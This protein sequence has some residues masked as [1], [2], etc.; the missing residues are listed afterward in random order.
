[1]KTDA[2]RP[3]IY[4]RI[5]NQIISS[6][7]QG[8]KPWTQP[9]NAAHAAGPVS[10]PLRHSGETYS[11][12]NV[13][14]LWATAMERGYAGPIWMTFKQAL[15]LG[16]CV[17]KGEKSSPVVYAGS[18][19]RTEQ[20]DKTGEDVERT[21]PFL[22]GYT[23][24]N[25]EQIDGLPAHYYAPAADTKNPDQRVAEADAFFASTRADIRHGGN[26]AFYAPG[27]DFVQMPNF[28]A[29]RSAED[30]YASLAHECTHW[31]RHKSRLDRDFG[32]EKFGDAGYAREELVAELGAAFLCA[33]L[34]LG[35]KD[36]DDHAA[37]IGHWLQVLRE[38]KRA[39]F[40]AA[41]H[42]QR[43]CD[44]LHGLQ[45]AQEEAA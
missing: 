39:I 36:R 38:D 22:K 3:D 21:I 19:N 37:Y 6:L 23:V 28:D 44:F 43:A 4:T 17:R 15:E 20:D 12:I 33:D 27:P 34:G 29:F 26:S 24:F 10:R 45:P 14:V 30:Y 11:G 18:L 5:T 41:A 16:G 1:M 13:L 7:E 8:V 40:S 32:R 42:A 35:L 25:I 2:N 9:W 31:T